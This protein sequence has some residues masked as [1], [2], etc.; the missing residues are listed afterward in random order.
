[1]YQENHEFIG[2]K[3]GV[4]VAW[5]FP[6]RYPEH[7]AARALRDLQPY[8]STLVGS[9]RGRRANVALLDIWVLLC[10]VTVL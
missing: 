1:V 2:E 7:G 8:L 4:R 3:F 9:D 5:L 6:N 10:V